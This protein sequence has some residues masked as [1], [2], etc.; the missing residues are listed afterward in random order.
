MRMIDLSI[1]AFFSLCVG[2]AFHRP[3]GAILIATAFI[4]GCSIAVLVVFVINIFRFGQM[5][6]VRNSRK[7]ILEPQ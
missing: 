5:A 1:A 2:A 4:I 3:I 7:M 6:A